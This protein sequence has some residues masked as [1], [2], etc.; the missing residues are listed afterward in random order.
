VYPTVTIY[1]RGA[2]FE[3]G[4]SGFYY[5]ENHHIDMVNHYY[6]ISILADEMRHAFQYLY[7]PDVYFATAYRTVREYLDCKI[8]WDA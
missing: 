4:M 3:S 6:G 1:E 8:E 7:F 5:S 2:E